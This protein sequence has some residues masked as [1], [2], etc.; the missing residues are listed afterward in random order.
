MPLYEQRTY[1]ILVGR[2]GELIELYTTVGWPLLEKYGDKLVGYFLGDVGA[3]NQLIHIWRFEDDADRR[4]F[5]KAFYDDPGLMEFASRLR[6]LLAAQENKLMMG[7][8]W[9]PLP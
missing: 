3:M 1:Q 6:P 5:W 8:A 9:G 2:K 4:T 7:A